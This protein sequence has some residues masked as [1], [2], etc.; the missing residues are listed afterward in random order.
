MAWTNRL[1]NL[2]R[3]GRLDAEI[4]EELRFHIEARVR[5]NLAAGMTAQEA[6]RDAMR[7]FVGRLQ[8]REASRDAD[9]LVWLQTIAQDAR[10]A[11]RGFR[12]NPGVSSI[13]V[14]SLGLAIGANTAIFSIVNAVLLR[15]FPYK[16][17]ARIAMLWT[18]NALNGSMEQNTSM[19]NLEDWRARSLS[20]EEMAAYRESDGPLMEAS[21]AAMEPE[22]TG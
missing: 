5:D 14:L 12:K 11:I 8:V 10:Y 3:R 20:F 9:V 1:M 22:W 17:S 16:D 19:P 13:A 7:R 2:F 21:G 6:R 15:A 4:E 18:S